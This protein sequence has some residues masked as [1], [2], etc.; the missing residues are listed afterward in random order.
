[1]NSNSYLSGVFLQQLERLSVLAKNPASGH[2]RGQHRSRRTG[3]GMIFSD[4]RPYV[5]GDDT[6]NIDW[7]IY[8]R[9]DR[10]VLRLFEEEADLPVY[11]FLDTSKSM[12]FGNPNKLQFSQRVAAALSYISLI[13]HD[14]VSLTTYDNDVRHVMPSRRGNKQIWRT[15]HLL[16]QVEGAGETD[17]KKSL[18]RFFGAKRSRGLV[19]VVSDF[20]DSNAHEDTFKVLHNGGH[21]VFAIQVNSPQEINPELSEDVFLVDSEASKTIDAQLT[22]KLMDRYQKEF[23]SHVRELEIFLNKHGWGYLKVGSDSSLEPMFFKLLRQRGL[24]R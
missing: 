21:D 7:G 11:V 20:F 8:L 17:L 9:L 6:R 16:D 4:Y 13:N 24:F 22:S 14:R 18:N 15:M 1:M 2:L 23:N 12:N 10:L 3:S 19:I 5:Q